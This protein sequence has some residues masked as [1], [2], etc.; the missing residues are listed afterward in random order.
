MANEI[1]YFMKEQRHI[2]GICPCCNEAF[3]L[4]DVRISYKAPYVKSWMDRLEENELK[5]DEAIDAYKEKSKEIRKN[6]IEAAKRKELPKVLKA[7]IP[8]FCNIG[9]SPHDVKVIMNPIDF[10]A[11][12]GMNTGKVKRVVLLDQKPVAEAQKKLHANLKKVIKDDALEWL[13]VKIG[14]DGGVG[15]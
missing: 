4:S 6:S 2:F 13:T 11:F 14:K 7:C 9:I 5:A 10:V 1:A 12:D 15:V 8:G 3:R